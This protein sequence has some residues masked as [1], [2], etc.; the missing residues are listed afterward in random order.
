[1][2]YTRISPLCCFI[3]LL[4]CVGIGRSLITV[5]VYHA[6]ST[7][8]LEPDSQE[9]L[10]AGRALLENGRF[11]L[12]PEHADIP[13]LRRT[14][15]YP[16]FIAGIYAIFG[17]NNLILILAQISISLLTFLCVYHIARLLWN[18]RIA[19]L[20]SVLL[21]CDLA[22]HINAQ[23]V[24]TDTL[25]TSVLTLALLV[26]L[27]A[28]RSTSRSSLILGSVFGFLLSIST[29]I[30]PVA[31]YLFFPAIAFLFWHW[32][33]Q[34]RWSYA[35]ILSGVCCMTLA[36][37]SLIWNWQIRNYSLCGSAEISHVTGSNLLFYCG[38]SLL[39]RHEG[40]TFEHA[41][42]TVGFYDYTTRFPET[43]AWSV[44][45][46]DQRWKREGLQLIRQYPRE[47]VRRQ[48]QGFLTIMLG[49]GEQTALRF[50]GISETSAGPIRDVFVVSREIYQTVWLLKHPVLVGICWGTGLALLVCYLCVGVSLSALIRSNISSSFHQQ[51]HL[52]LWMVLLCLLMLSVFSGAEG[53]S[54]FRIPIM[55]IISVYAAHGASVMFWRIRRHK[56]TKTESVA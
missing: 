27:L 1:M 40:M 19:L 11:S 14:P 8:I 34:C 39:A 32:K 47:F 30:R 12:S 20:A 16:L 21:S 55:P 52:L 6:D 5:M 38:A 48:L 17:E 45:Q 9:Y 42:R 10:D 51:S 13:Q 49:I 4:L 53:Y 50:L 15:G 23:Q 18:A 36:W 28:L 29:F 2:K 22:S 26:A 37:G 33:R 35:T 44:C 43:Q 25:F 7:R 3:L 24:L 56:P 31:Y 41:Q 46:L 54:R